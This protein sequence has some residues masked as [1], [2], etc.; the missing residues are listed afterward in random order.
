MFKF[1]IEAQVY[2]TDSGTQLTGDSRDLLALLPADSIDLIMTSPPF[3]LLRQKTYGNELQ[4]DYVKGLRG[5][6]EAAPTV[7]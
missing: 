5:F 1:P 6:G 7:Y 4:A 2:A 3:A